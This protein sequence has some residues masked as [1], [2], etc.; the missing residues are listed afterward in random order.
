ML[1]YEEGIF[2]HE[3]CNTLFIPQT[4]R[5]GSVTT[6]NQTIAKQSMYFT[7]YHHTN[8]NVE[9]YINKKEEPIIVV[10][11]ATTQVSKPPRPLNYP[12][13]IY[14]IVGHKLTNC[15]RFREM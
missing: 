10:I 14:G 13:H 8:H 12:C 3:T 15:P 1:I 9:T 7:N 5:I 6:G 2:R 4:S 11:E